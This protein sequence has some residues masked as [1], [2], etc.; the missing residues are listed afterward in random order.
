MAAETHQTEPA[1]PQAGQ[2]QSW[3][4]HLEELVRRMMGPVA[5]IGICFTLS[6]MVSDGLLDLLTHHL[7]LEDRQLRIYKP[8]ELLAVKI[9][10]SMALAMGL[11]M[12]LILYQG[13]LFAAPGLYRQ[14]RRF[15]LWVIP[16]SLLLFLTGAGLAPIFLA[17]RLMGLMVEAA[18][19][20]PVE[21]ALSLERTLT[22][23]FTLVFGLGLAFQLPLIIGLGLKLELFTYE[24]LKAKR[25][26]LYG[27]MILL[28]IILA[29]DPSLMAQ[30]V[31]LAIMVLIL[32][33]TLGMARLTQKITAIG[34]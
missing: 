31:V 17:P 28:S 11:G 4:V 22:P 30:L 13:Y 18:E 6:F 20:G 3:E 34:S 32:E 7:D 10:L 26:Y 12:P 23:I 2:A 27:S 9:K 15:A 14:E 29:P 21:V 24:Q 33:L 19:G 1:K 25:P 5:L 8:T 16:S